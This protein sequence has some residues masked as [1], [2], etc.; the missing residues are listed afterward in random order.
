MAK[1]F[2]S[3]QHN[4]WL[5]YHNALGPAFTQFFEG[6]K[7]GKIL[8]TRCPNCSK[9]QVPGRSFC[10]QCQVDVSE[11]VEL[12]QEGKV[13]SW[14]VIREDFIGAPAEAPYISALIQLDGTD[15]KLLHVVGGDRSWDA[16]KNEPKIGCGNRVKAVW[17][18]EKRGH[19]TDIQ[20]FQPTDE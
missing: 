11:W 10:P 12:A 16:D 20:Y 9:V 15:C 6:F 5:P 7:E 4:V 13:V 2:S 14:T 3:N 18:E 19:M 8:G 17:R 1:H